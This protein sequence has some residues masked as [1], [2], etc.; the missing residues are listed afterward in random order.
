[1]KVA[2][3]VPRYGD[4]VVGGAEFAARLLAE[5]LVARG[6]FEVEVLTTRAV[7]ARTW[8]NEYPE[9]EADL[10]GV[11]VR[12]FTGAGRSPSFDAFSGPLLVHPEAVASADQARWLDAQGPVSPDLID[13][14]RETDAAVVVLTPYLFHPT[15]RGLPEVRGRAVLHPAAHDEPMLRL[16]MFRDVFGGADGLVFYTHAEQRLVESR[17]PT[18]AV[19][20]IVLGLGCDPAPAFPSSA[21]APDVSGGRPYVL[22]LGRVEGA[23]GTDALA[24][25]FIRFKER[26]PSSLAL[27]FVG[28]V[29]DAPP[30]HR[31]VIVTGVVDEATKWAVLRDA[32]ALVSPSAYESFGLVL[33]EAWQAGIPVVVNGASDATRELCERSAG[34]LWF[35]NDAEFDVAL[36]RIVESPDVRAALARSGAR[37]VGEKLAWPVIIDRYA[38][39]LRTL[40]GAG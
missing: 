29:L 21:H 17:F 20:Q 39:F 16:P 22:C 3:V 18:A 30:E 12:R 40:T 27:V 28:P 32:Q 5:R 15:V 35:R 31:D 24:R 6:G 36:R 4:E 10:R 23:K 9:G 37:Y 14:V 34:G 38:D 26:H 11:H 8:D 19:P 25:A 33:L 7:N 1:M 2:Y 13:A